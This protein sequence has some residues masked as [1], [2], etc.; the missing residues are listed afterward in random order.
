MKVAIIGATG[1]GGAELVR[2][3]HTHPHVS[4]HSIHASSMYGEQLASSYPHMHTL[5]D[6]RLQQVDIE[7]IAKEVDLVF[8]ATPS[9]VARDLAPQLLEAGVKVI[10]IS[11]DFRIKDRAAYKEWYGLEAAEEHLL[12]EAVYGLTEW[13][14]V[15]ISD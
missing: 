5:V 3:L 2:I 6:D 4:I 8:T 15:D 13:I 1:Y 14:E 10:D 9:G 7:K 11:G 12:N